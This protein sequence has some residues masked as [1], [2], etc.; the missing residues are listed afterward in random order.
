MAIK[1][2][3]LFDMEPM[4]MENMLYA[5]L[6]KSIEMLHTLGIET[7]PIDSISINTRASSFWGI[8][9]FNRKTMSN[10]IEI[11]VRL[12]KNAWK[13]EQNNISYGF[14]NKPLM[15]TILHECIHCIEGCHNHGENW[16]TIAEKVNSHYGFS[17]SRTTSAEELNVTEMERLEGARYVCE[18]PS[19]HT[20]IA[21]NRMTKLMKMPEKYICTNCLDSGVK[22]RFVRIK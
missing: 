3:P 2:D 14:K 8:T 5:Y 22:S 1:M 6:N 16:K 21:R 17:I 20:K 15:Q 11:S 4:M 10:S 12:V 7:E 18:C 13:E 9:K 19:C